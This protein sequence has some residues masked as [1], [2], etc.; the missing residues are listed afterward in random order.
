MVIDASFSPSQFSLITQSQTLLH[1]P[2]S[3]HDQ[4]TSLLFLFKLKQHA[5]QINVHDFS[6]MI[7]SDL[8][9][10]QSYISIFQF[11]LKINKQKN[12]H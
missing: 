12:H 6:R 9:R 1:Q 2:C 11:L 3:D 7:F 10:S 8:S 5:P 4:K